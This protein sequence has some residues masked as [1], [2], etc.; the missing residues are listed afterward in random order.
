MKRIAMLLTV[1]LI[2]VLCSGSAYAMEGEYQWRNWTVHFEG[3]K[4]DANLPGM[5]ADKYA[6]EG[7]LTVDEVLWKDKDLCQALTDEARLI[8]AEGN[9]YKPDMGLI[10][11]DEPALFFAFYVPK[12]ID[13]E[14]LTFTLGE[15]QASVDETDIPA[16]LTGEWQGVG[17]PKGGGSSIDLIITINP[18]GTG[19]YTFDQSGYHESNPFSITR[20][21]SRFTVNTDESMLDGCEGTWSL[22]DDV[23]ILDITSTLSG[24]RVFTYTAECRKKEAPATAETS[25]SQPVAQVPHIQLPKVQVPK[26]PVPRVPL[27]KVQ[28]PT[29]QAP[30]VASPV[31]GNDT[32]EAPVPTQQ[33][34]SE[35]AE[36]RIDE[37]IDA[38]D[39]DVYR[40]T[41]DAL[42]SGEVIQKGSRGD[43]AKGVQ[44]TLVDFSQRIAVDGSV[45]QKTI[46]ALNAVQS[47]FG[48]PNTQM[49]DAEG[50]A[51]LL[52]RLMMVVKPDEAEAM[53][54]KTMDDGEYDYLSACALE[55]QGK[56]YT[57][58]CRFAQSGWGDWEDRAAACVQPWPKNGQLYKN[59]DVGGSST[60]LTV[61]VN[62]SSDNAMY[63]KIYTKDDVL[64][65]TLFIGGTG[66]ATTK[67]P[68][69]TY[70]I[71]DGTGKDWYG[72][73]EAFGDDAYYE[74]MTFNG[75]QTEV[76]LK[77]NY[78]STITINVKQ[79]D[80]KGDRVG[81]ARE[82]YR[83]F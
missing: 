7:L 53:L 38:L 78:A 71:K 11:A 19:K 14:T 9:A 45:G 81:S 20:D 82:N 49:L 22:K 32:S 40:K 15:D 17:T 48:L 46:A 47:A 61:K 1:L 83:D 42:L 28:V 21:G 18:D 8:D 39:N 54:K 52:P 2:V 13:A 3:G 67:L 30:T 34:A 33:P 58:K 37:V 27:P 57:A 25:M 60:Q 31:A 23:L 5:T 50:Y 6:F 56:Y 24:G 68:A 51:Q 44:Q 26:V 69:G 43:T 74:I 62:T 4:S 10:L 41:Y 75:G 77:R 29:I 73:A 64:A 79:G 70:V 76:E 12:A 66:R 35:P 16:E 65:R 36:V 72:E 55:A 63:V 59:P 80:A